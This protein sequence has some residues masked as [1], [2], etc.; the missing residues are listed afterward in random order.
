MN[1]LRKSSLGVDKSDLLEA[2]HAEVQFS[3]K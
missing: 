1:L 2:A 3:S